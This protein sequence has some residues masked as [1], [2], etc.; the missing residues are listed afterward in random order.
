[1]V[2]A[3]IGL[4]IFDRVA[5]LTFTFYAFTVMQTNV[6]C[7]FKMLNGIANPCKN[8]LML[9]LGILASIF[10]VSIPIFDMYEW[11]SIHNPCAAIF[12]STALIDSLMY[13][14]E[15]TKHKDKFPNEDH[16]TID[17]LAPLSWITLGSA[18]ACGISI[19]LWGTHHWAGPFFEWTTVGL[20]L[21][22]YLVIQFTNPYLSSIT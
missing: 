15:M 18:I 7:Y 21:N 8:D 12:F 22:Y 17:R 19:G 14:Y 13:S 2:S 4:P 20:L 9:V 10:M 1:M 16:S 6:R 11:S 3:V 5:S